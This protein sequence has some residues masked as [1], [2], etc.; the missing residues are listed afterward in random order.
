MS[1]KPFN[2]LPVR[3]N[4]IIQ[5]EISGMT[6]EGNGVGKY[7]GI[8]VF[9]PFTAIGDRI[10]CRIVKI[11]KNYCYGIS[12]EINVSSE[13][14]ISVDCPVF[15]K[16]GGCSFR[17]I[18]YES[19]CK[20]KEQ[21]VSDAFKRIGK[22]DVD[23]SPIISAENT[24]YYRNKAQYPVS[25]ENGKSICGF[26]SRRSHRVI[27]YISCKLHPKIFEDIVK[28]ILDF[29]NDNGILAYN[30]ETGKGVL[31]HIFIRK[32][33][34]TDEIMV[35]LV[36]SCK[37]D[38]LY[39]RLAKK[40]T[41][42]I[43]NIK[44][45]MLNINPDKTNVIMGK[46]TICLSGR[47]YIF[48]IMCDRK[49]ILSAQSFYQINTEQ[50]E[51]LYSIAAEFAELKGDETLIDLYCG[52]GT[53]GLSMADKVKR[54]IGVEVVPEAIENAKKNA[55]LNNIENA[56]F[57]CADA[58]QASLKLEYDN[59]NPDIVILDPPR[60][61]CDIQTIEAVCRMSP[62]KVIMISCNPSTAARDL[63]QFNKNNYK[64]EKA[65]PLD[66]FPRTPHVECVVLM[67]RQ[68]RKKTRQ[69]EI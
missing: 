42:E 51:R 58:G 66:L 3:K 46:R 19:E 45:V 6:S 32:G 69:I 14:R 67:S 28:R 38:K 60:K 39:S 9:V 13:N 61:G 4:E 57:I 68:Q 43:E 8:A 44:S 16:C 17:H 52:A 33:F 27:P 63:A 54:L 34:H 22:L 7:E 47:D 55:E 2:N 64:I 59:I 65:I 30:E 1:K 40:L 35:C 25:D 29:Q 20:I 53:I 56:E 12:E 48:D 18:S 50:A 26:Y 23:L 24:I 62:K 21:Y 10:S 11:E 15:Q 31:R 49:V 36:A 41:E 5:I 37:A